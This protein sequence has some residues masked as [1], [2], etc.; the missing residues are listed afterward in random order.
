[1][2]KIK[3]L[4]YFLFIALFATSCSKSSDATADLGTQIAGTYNITTLTSGTTV[5]TEA[6]MSAIRLLGGTAKITV[7]K[8]TTT[9]VTLAIDVNIPGTGAPIKES[10][11]AELVDA[12]GGTINLVDP[13]TKIS[14]GTVSNGKITIAAKSGGVNVSMTATK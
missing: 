6:Q 7:T 12:G 13:I 3:I 4:F 2:Q 5:I 1:M 8:K 14:G 11:E 10:I 9:L